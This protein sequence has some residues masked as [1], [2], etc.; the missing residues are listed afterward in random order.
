MYWRENMHMSVGRLLFGRAVQQVC[1]LY[2]LVKVPMTLPS[3][4]LAT[5]SQSWEAISAATFLAR[6]KKRDKIQIAASLIQL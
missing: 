2:L 5:D 1:V 4:F 6:K 3:S